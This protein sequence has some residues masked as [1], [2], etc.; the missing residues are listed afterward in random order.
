MTYPHKIEVKEIPV[1]PK[2]IMTVISTDYE[3]HTTKHEFYAEPE[4]FLAFWKPLVEYYERVKNAN[5]I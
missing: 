4:E 5:S 1:P 3:T 2:T